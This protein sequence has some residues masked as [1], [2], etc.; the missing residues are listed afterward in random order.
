MT[1]QHSSDERQN[2]VKAT[3]TVGIV[4]KYQLVTVLSNDE[5]ETS[6]SILKMWFSELR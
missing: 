5:R 4:P 6:Y 3:P 2:P 1:L